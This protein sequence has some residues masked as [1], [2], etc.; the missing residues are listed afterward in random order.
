MSETLKGTI[1]EQ[2]EYVYVKL[3]EEY[4][5]LYSNSSPEDRKHLKAMHGAA[6]DAYWRAESDDLRDDNLYVMRLISALDKTNNDIEQAIQQQ[7]NTTKMIALFAEAVKLAAA[8]VTLAAA[9]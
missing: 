4:D 8:V 2:A 3:D 5:R 1:V 7:L 9:A 6:R